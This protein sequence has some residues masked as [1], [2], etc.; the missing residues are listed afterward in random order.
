M[1]ME[2]KATMM[3]ASPMAVEAGKTTVTVNVSGSGTDALSLLTRKKARNPCGTGASGYPESGVFVGRVTGL[4]SRRPCSRL[5]RIHCWQRWS[6]EHG[7]RAQLFGRGELHGGSFS[8]S[9]SLVASS[10]LMPVPAPWHP[11]AFAPAASVP[12]QMALQVMPVVAVSRAVTLV[13]TPP[14]RAWLPRRL[15]LRRT[16]KPCTEA[17]LMMRPQLCLHGGKCQ[18]RGVKSAGL[19]DGQNGVPALDRK[20]FD[21]GRMLNACV[22]DRMSTAPNCATLYWAMSS[23]SALRDISAPW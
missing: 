20:V 14:R 5:R 1:A 12:G 7:Q 23:I 11:P 21:A 3:D 9:S 19:V 10:L 8:P 22:V 15:I 4:S 16:H 2:A 13:R 18:A 17:T 6:K